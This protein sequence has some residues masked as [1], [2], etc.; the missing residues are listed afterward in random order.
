MTVIADPASDRTPRPFDYEARF[1]ETLRG[2]RAEGRYRT[3]REIDRDAGAYPMAVWN[4]P[5]GPRD[6][7]VW[8]S[9]DYLGMSRHPAVIEAM[10]DV[11]HRHG[12]GAGGTR[13]LS[14]TSGAVVALERELADLHAKPAALAFSSGYVAN[15]TSLAALGALLPGAVFLSD[16]A[17]HNSI[18]EG[19]RRAGGDKRIFRHNDV[20]HLKEL[21]GEIEPERPKVVVFESVYSMEGDIAPIR[22]ICDVAATRG[23]FTYLDEVHAVGLYGQRGAGVAERDGVMERIDLIQ[24]T[25]GKGF[26]VVGGYIAGSRALIDAVRSTAPGLIFTTALPPALCAA[27]TAAVRA[28]KADQTGRRGLQIQASRTREA[29]RAAGLPAGGAPSHIVPVHVGDAELCRTACERLL[30]RHGLY[31]QPVNYPTVARGTER[32]RITPSPAHGDGRIAELVTALREVWGHLG[33]PLT[34]G[35]L[36]AAA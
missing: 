7:V 27:A 25:L 2:L 29:L 28:L 21:L 6:I 17:N 34:R 24:G 32:L 9:N 20:D 4:S 22:A 8:C 19:V 15:Q 3:F 14:G 11:A 31:I 1:G 30:E 33:L 16:A 35:R 13:N 23:A 26:G 36:E 10:V 5:E 12:V 18:I